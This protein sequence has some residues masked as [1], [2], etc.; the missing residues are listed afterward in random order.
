MS[1]SYPQWYELYSLTV[2]TPFGIQR[3]DIIPLITDINVNYTM[4]MASQLSF[5]VVDIDWKFSQANYFML[6][7]EVILTDLAT[8]QFSVF[9]IAAISVEQGDAYNMP[10]IGIECRTKAVQEMKRDKRLESFKSMSATEFA[11]IVAERHGLK[12]YGEST[13]KVQSIVK[14]RSSNSDE[15][16]WDV[17]RRL[18]NDNQFVV[19]ETSGTLFFCSERFLL[20]KLG[21]G[22]DIGTQLVTRPSWPGVDGAIQSGD[23]GQGVELLQYYFNL[24]VTGT[25]GSNLSTAVRTYQQYTGLPVTGTVD[26][27]TWESI[28]G[29]LGSNWNYVPMVYPPKDTR[30][31]VMEHPQ[32]RRSDDDPYEASGSLVVSRENAV[33]L[34]PG[35]TVSV[36]TPNPHINGA[37]LIT[38]VDFPLGGANP[39]KLEIRTPA[40]LEPDKTKAN[41][42]TS[43]TST[44]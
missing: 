10:K 34:R 27:V 35:M 1:L 31:I 22:T 44:Q 39:V 3:N 11:S 17:L 15:S 9:E 42:Y 4:D 25:W 29:L 5:T 24:P 2:S 21:T 6:R 12:I 32:V 8:G 40:Q 28:F 19:F 14:S 16:I 33:Q 36:D 18:A 7:R 20:G 30:F 43:Q 38:G 13:N 37:Y 23:S 26:K 41:S